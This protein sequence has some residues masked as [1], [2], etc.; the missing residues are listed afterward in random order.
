MAAGREVA[1]PDRGFDLVRE[2]EVERDGAVA[3]D[4][5]QRPPV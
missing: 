4:G 3:V 2:L 5:E 1:P